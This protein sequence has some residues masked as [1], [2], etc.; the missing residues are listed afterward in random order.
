MM[1]ENRRMYQLTAVQILVPTPLTSNL[2][3]SPCCHGMFPDPRAY[4]A[5]KRIMDP[6][7]SDAS[8]GEYG[9][10]GFGRRIPPVGFVNSNP[11]ARVWCSV[12]TIEKDRG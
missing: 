9:S 10:G 1:E 2:N 12:L 5:T 7:T 8:V 11:S 3:S 6:K 4:P